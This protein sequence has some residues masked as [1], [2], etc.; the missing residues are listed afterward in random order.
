MP[1]KGRSGDGSPRLLSGHPLPYLANPLAPA[2][3]QAR[4]RSCSST[5]QVGLARVAQSRE[6]SALQGFGA[7]GTKKKG[8]AITAPPLKG[9]D[10]SVSSP[11]RQTTEAVRVLN[12][13]E[14]REES[15]PILRGR[16][17]AWGWISPIILSCRLAREEF[18]LKTLRTCNIKAP[19]LIPS[20]IG[21]AARSRPRI[22]QRP[23]KTG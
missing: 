2:L 23:D 18:H 13:S 11:K 5:R 14:P 15:S 17:P 6:T 10:T 19:I 3:I 22:V 21:L 9:S 4:S 16:Y 1:R 20:G 12:C 8:G 7:L